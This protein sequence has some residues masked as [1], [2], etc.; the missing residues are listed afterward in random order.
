MGVETL[1]ALGAAVGG[2]ISKASG[3]SF[4][5][6]AALG[7][8]T[9]GV[10]VGADRMTG[11]HLT[12]KK[13]DPYAKNPAGDLTKQ[14]RAIITDSSDKARRLLMSGN[15]QRL[16]TSTGLTGSTR[17]GSSARKRLLGA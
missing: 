7:S 2:G 3:G 10:G 17:S 13:K 12:K 11:G 4:W 15:P 6:G 9:G 16:V 5:K 14:Q 8:L 1:I